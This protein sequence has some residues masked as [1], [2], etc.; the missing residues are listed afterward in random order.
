MK[1]I[2]H[3]IS[4]DVFSGAENVACQIING[5]SK[6]EKYKMIY[7]SKIGPNKKSLEDRSITYY[8]LNNFNYKC[9]KKAIQ[10]FKPDIIH[11]HDIKAS[12]YASL[13]YKKAVI[14]SHIHGNHENMRKFNL[15]TFLYNMFSKRF[16]KIIWVSKSCLEDY[17][18]S[19][20]I[21]DKSIIL[22]NVINPEEIYQ[23]AKQDK[24][25]YSFDIIYLGRMTY[26]KNPL[27]LIDVVNEVI[28][29]RPQTTVA[30]VGTGELDKDVKE[31]I[32]EYK[33][34]KNITFFGFQENP[35]K[36]LVSSK[37][38]LMTSRYEGTPMCALEALAC[39]VPIISTP[40]DGLLELIQ[41]GENGYICSTNEDLVE[42]TLTIIQDK[43]NAI[44]MSKRVKLSSKKINNIIKYLNTINKIYVESVN[45][46]KKQKTI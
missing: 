19:N 10:D 3:L 5:F 45:D 37:V 11:A 8:K 13:F 22:Y 29:Q 26:P 4:T 38:M 6:D 31:K 27:R 18:Y 33:L 24:N 1:K 28:K 14:I 7:V 23:K 39:G 41:N 17:Y 12:I 15:K 43:S 30:L 34:E 40:T 2:M 36:I 20:K 16:N 42:K 25:K 21:Q 35:Y 46:D 44:E 32:H 9:I